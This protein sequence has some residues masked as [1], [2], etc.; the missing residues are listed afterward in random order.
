MEDPG[1][2]AVSPLSPNFGAI[3]GRKKTQSVRKSDVVVDWAWS[4]SQDPSRHSPTPIHATRQENSQA[5]ATK[6]TI[7]QEANKDESPSTLK[8]KL[9]KPEE[10]TERVEEWVREQLPDKHAR[11]IAL[12]VAQAIYDEDAHPEPG[13]IRHLLDN[14]A[15]VFGNVNGYRLQET[16][17]DARLNEMMGA[18]A[19][20]AVILKRVNDAA[21][22][23]APRDRKAP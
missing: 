10:A 12:S 1:R 3:L 22:E 8:R 16:Y 17:N 2:R 13:V 4:Q 19:E 21:R 11:T 5:L 18:S 20:L 23:I 6:D 7:V 9:W 14:S 15:E